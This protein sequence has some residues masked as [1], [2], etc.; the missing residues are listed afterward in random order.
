M[1]NQL[2]AN[3]RV[4]A[5]V[6]AVTMGATILLDPV[7]VP[8]YL[9]PSADESS[10]LFESIIV[11]LNLGWGLFGSWQTKEQSNGATFGF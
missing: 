9:E 8:T 10:R 11:G 1:A 5:L 6:A 4:P 3:P 7:L 2:P